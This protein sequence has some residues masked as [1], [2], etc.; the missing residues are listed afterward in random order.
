MK[1]TATQSL[2]TISSRR[3]ST[4][5]S[6]KDA[7]HTL[8]SLSSRR[9]SET[10]SITEKKHALHSLNGLSSRRISATLSTQDSHFSHPSRLVQQHPLT[11]IISEEPS[12]KGSQEPAF[13]G[14]QESTL[15]DITILEEYSSFIACGPEHMLAIGKKLTE[16]SCN[17]RIQS[18]EW[19]ALI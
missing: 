19:I 11:Q 7:V 6:T 2:N 10:L 9:E 12:F 13:K 17:K 1:N 15:K 5:Q 8:T 18:M 4:A 3:A 14:T 16:F